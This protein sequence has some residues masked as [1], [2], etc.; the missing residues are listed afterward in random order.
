MGDAY[1]LLCVL[2]TFWEASE[3]PSGSTNRSSSSPESHGT[4]NCNEHEGEKV[5]ILRNR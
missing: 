3:Y 4:A 1:C 2:K 5:D